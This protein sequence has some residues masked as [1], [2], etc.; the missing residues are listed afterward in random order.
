MDKHIKFKAAKDKKNRLEKKSDY[1]KKNRNFFPRF[2]LPKFQT[3][4]ISKL[5][6]KARF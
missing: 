4:Q 3:Y 5:L 2:F 1:T 6:S